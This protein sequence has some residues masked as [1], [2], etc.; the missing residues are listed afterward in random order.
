MAKT[1]PSPDSRDRALSLAPKKVRYRVTS[2]DLG[3][4][5]PP[6]PR[7]G[8]PLDASAVESCRT[9]T[10]QWGSTSMLGD[11][12]PPQLGRRQT[13]S[14]VREWSSFPTALG[15]QCLAAGVVGVEGVVA[16]P[17]RGEA[18]PVV[19]E[20]RILA[21]PSVLAGV[22]DGEHG[23]GVRGRWQHCCAGTIS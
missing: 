17:S 19:E 6:S 20:A 16:L 10:R 12:T 14:R 1:A 21:R 8:R 3:Q 11:T 9:S 5:R 15:R 23:L 13:S 18:C 4:Y 22:V 7:P 2:S